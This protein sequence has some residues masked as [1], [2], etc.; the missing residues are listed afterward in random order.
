MLVKNYEEFP[1]FLYEIV[2][3]I[4]KTLNPNHR[5]L[6]KNCIEK[7]SKFLYKLVEKLPIV[8]LSQA[9]QK[10]AISTQDSLIIVYDLRTASNYKI[11]K[12]S[13]SVL[14]FNASGKKIAA[15]STK[16]CN[17]KIWKL[18]KG[19]LHE[20]LHSQNKPKYVIDLGTVE[21]LVGSYKEFLDRVRIAWDDA[22]ISLI[23]EDLRAYIF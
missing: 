18:K 21:N 9:S 11:L 20:M 12:N 1:Q 6:R 5:S 3:I 17:L 10:L 2:E 13:T 4:M 23:R 15:Y 8:S 16:D 22:G 19:F 7:S 14:S